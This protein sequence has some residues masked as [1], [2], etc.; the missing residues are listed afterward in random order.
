VQKSVEEADRSALVHEEV[1][2]QKK[3]IDEEV[4]KNLSLLVR[5]GHKI[6][7]LLKCIVGLACL[8]I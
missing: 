7:I 4:T 6:L 3:P 2:Q 1:N 8:A 5:I